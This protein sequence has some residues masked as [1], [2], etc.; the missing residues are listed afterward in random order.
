MGNR[1][2]LTVAGMDGKLGRNS[3]CEGGEVWAQVAQEVV[4]SPPLELKAL[5]G[6]EQPD[7]VEDSLL[8]AGVWNKTIFKV[9]PNPSRTLTHTSPIMACSSGPEEPSSVPLNR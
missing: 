1:F 5:W 7:L 3:S 2:K 9:L 4:G 8:V 6:S